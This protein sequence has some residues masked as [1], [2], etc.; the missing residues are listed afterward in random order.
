MKRFI[1][2]EYSLCLPVC[3]CLYQLGLCSVS[4][5][6]NELLSFYHFC[7]NIK[8]FFISF[9]RVIIVQDFETVTFYV[10]FVYSIYLYVLF[11]FFC[12]LTPTLRQLV[13]KQK[14]MS[15]RGIFRLVENGLK[16]A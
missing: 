13:F 15:L 6:T 12:L 1:D 4:Y 11:V 3:F 9:L 7:I 8:D 16:G 5:T 14:K 10:L 2:M